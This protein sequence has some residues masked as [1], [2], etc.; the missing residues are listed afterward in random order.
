MWEIE[1]TYS[2]AIFHWNVQSR[3]EIK[4]IL[5]EARSTV[6]P[7]H[8]WDDSE[9]TYDDHQIQSMDP[10]EV[11]VFLDG[12]GGPE[13]KRLRFGE[14]GKVSEGIFMR[15]LRKSLDGELK[16][17]EGK[18]VGKNVKIESPKSTKSEKSDISEPTPVPVAGWCCILLCKRHE[19]C[20][21]KNR[22]F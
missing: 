13:R 4:E 10:D 6:K 14:D 3:D 18:V 5:K 12:L 11:V 22:S 2:V 19:F 8:V 7:D 9:Y 21:H 20:S 15:P 1:F 17:G 16:W